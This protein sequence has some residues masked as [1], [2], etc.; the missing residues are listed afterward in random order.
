MKMKKTWVGVTVVALLALA[1]AAC[2][3]GKQAKQD[4]ARQQ[5]WQELQANKQKLDAKRKQLADLRTQLKE[6][7]AASRETHGRHS[8]SE[9]ASEAAKP[10][11]ADLETQVKTLDKDVSTESDQFDQS[12]VDFINAKPIVEGTPPT[13]IQKQAIRMKSDEDMRLAQEYITK[14]GDYRHAIEIYNNALAVDPDYQALKD[15]LAKAQE[16][17]YMTKDRF[18]KVKK[19]MTADEVREAIGQANLYNVKDYPEKHVTAW[20]YP[21]KDGGAAGVFYRKDTNT[22]KLKVYATNFD[23]VKPQVETEK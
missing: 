21:K 22:G 9:E 23:A 12:L 6:A 20:F 5:Q 15:A 2:G 19:N 8:K 3:G 11:V 17:R 16:D 13:E 10:T 14:G 4:A 18:D 7:E 1:A